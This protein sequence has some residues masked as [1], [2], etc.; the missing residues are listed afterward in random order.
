MQKNLVLKFVKNVVM[1]GYLNAA[2]K[3]HYI[4]LVGKH[5]NH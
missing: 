1:W 2:L 5:P 4:A 3:C